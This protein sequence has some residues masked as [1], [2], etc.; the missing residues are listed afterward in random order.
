MQINLGQLSGTQKAELKLLRF[1][2]AA[3]VDNNTASFEDR[4]RFY[5]AYALLNR[6]R[7]PAAVRADDTGRL[8]SEIGLEELLEEETLDQQW[9]KDLVPESLASSED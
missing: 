5:S 2:L 1:R 6:G 4:K 3:S 7:T 8:A 9:D